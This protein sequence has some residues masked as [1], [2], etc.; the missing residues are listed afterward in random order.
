MNDTH[1][2]TIIRR[3]VGVTGSKLGREDGLEWG[4][5]RRDTVRIQRL[6]SSGLP[7]PGTKRQ[8]GTPSALIGRQ[9]KNFGRK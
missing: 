6:L 7:L 2:K 5:H 9:Y 8:R 1:T 3:R 4:Q